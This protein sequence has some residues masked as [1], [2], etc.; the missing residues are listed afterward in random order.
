MKRK[1]VYICLATVT[2]VV[3]VSLNC[4]WSFQAQV[5]SCSRLKPVSIKSPLAMETEAAE[6]LLR[7]GVTFRDLG[8]RDM[9]GSSNGTYLRQ[10]FESSDGVRIHREY[11]DYKSY[12]IAKQVFEAERWGEVT[13]YE[14]N[15][16]MK[17]GR[18]VGVF[19]SPEFF[20]QFASVRLNDRKVTW[21]E[22]PSLR[23]I[24]AFEKSQR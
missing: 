5:A 23:Y 9:M 17:E 8:N 16:G 12:S 13:I 15:E 22:A 18:V 19:K 1:I 11:G 6:D 21:I 14:D 7:R 10:D 20:K 4:I 24:L 3:G 2:F